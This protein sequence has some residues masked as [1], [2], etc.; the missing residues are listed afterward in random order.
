MKSTI[1]L[2]VFL[3]SLVLFITSCEVE[4]TNCRKVTND[5]ESFGGFSWGT[6]ILHKQSIGY[7]SAEK[8]KVFNDIYFHQ[9]GRNIGKDIHSMLTVGDYGSI[10]YENA[11]ILEWINMVNFT[12]DGTV[13]IDKPRNI[14]ANYPNFL[15]SF[16]DRLTGG[17]AVI[18]MTSKRIVDTLQTGTT[19][20]AFCKHGTDLYVF[21]D[22]KNV[23]DSIIWRLR[24]RGHPSYA[25]FK[26]N[27]F[28]VGIRP[29]DGVEI[30]IQRADYTHEGLAILCLGGIADPA[31]IV[32]LDLVTGE[33]ADKYLFEST[34]VKPENLFWLY[35][36]FNNSNRMISYI[37]N[38]L[39]SITLDNPVETSILVDRN[40]SR[41]YPW[42]EYYLGVSRDTT[43]ATS[44]LYRF[45]PD[46]FEPVDSLAID[47]RALDI[48][49]L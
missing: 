18:D 40:V 12:S 26:E 28:V 9:N 6:F 27:S 25:Y 31:S 10:S 48:L 22:G 43:Q 38:R 17:I 19:A 41:L 29:V 45:D 39:Y 16:G 42:I 30:N 3:N 37:G 34:D 13:E 49:G 14:Y 11:N 32:L 4:W 21:T 20:G 8:N 46:M 7:Y 47:G 15:V 1:R 2:I 44:Y 24:T 5:E 33:V 36:Y 23:Q 35:D